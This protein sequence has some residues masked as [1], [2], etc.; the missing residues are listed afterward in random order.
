MRGGVQED[1]PVHYPADEGSGQ[2]P[3]CSLDNNHAH[4]ILVEPGPPGNG[5]GPTELRLRLEKH[6]S[7]QRTGYGGETCPGE[8]GGVMGAQGVGRAGRTPRWAGKGIPG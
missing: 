6:I 7:E 1:G 3:L 2:G 5:D 8:G 4:F